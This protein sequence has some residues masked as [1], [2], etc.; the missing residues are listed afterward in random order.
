MKASTNL[1]EALPISTPQLLG[2]GSNSKVCFSQSH[3]S[4]TQ[5]T[6]QLHGVYQHQTAFSR[7]LRSQ[8][9]P[10]NLP[11]SKHPTTMV[12]PEE[13]SQEEVVAKRQGQTWGKISGN[14]A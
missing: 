3:R 14:D 4:Q 9:A 10:K 5:M 7:R 12:L 8:A 6:R 11:I 2:H 1:P 13:K